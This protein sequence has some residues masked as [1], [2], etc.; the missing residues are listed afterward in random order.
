LKKQLIITKDGSH[1]FFVP[2][3]S[4]TY[5]S[6]H[7]AITEAKHVFIKNG[8]LAANKNKVNILEVGFGTGLNALLTMQKVKQQ[9]LNVFYNSLEPHPLEKQEYI[10]LNYAVLLNCPQEDFINLHKSEWGKEI[11][12]SENFTL[13]KT[14]ESVRNFKTEKKFDIIYF[15]AFAPEKQAEM[16]TKTVFEKMYC[17]LKENG[18]LVTY[19]AMGVV[20][21][22]L[23]SVGLE[24]ETLEGSPG[25]REMIRANKK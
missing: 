16:W 25:K 21:R 13:Y 5:H 18:F 24:V 14:E 7:G 3:L 4:E 1:S 17:L 9:N 8:L 15:D 10:K 23:K 19:C 20:K 11:K 2:E 12:L 22:T 6:K